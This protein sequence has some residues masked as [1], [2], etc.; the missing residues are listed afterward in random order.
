[1]ANLPPP[2]SEGVATGDQ[3]LLKRINSAALLR[4]VRTGSGLSRA[5]LAKRS[6]L[7]KSTVSLLVQEL[8]DDGWIREAEVPV[9][10]A[11]GR[12]PTPLAMDN[13]RLALLGAEIGVDYLNVVACD[14]QGRVLGEQFQPHAPGE[15][16]ATLATLVAMLGQQD[17]ALA[18]QGR[19]LLGVGVGIPGTVH[20]A[21][22]R[23]GVVPN[24]GWAGQEI[25]AP[26]A[27]LLVKGGV[28]VAPLKV[29]NEANAAALSEYVFG[30]MEGSGEG[31]HPDSLIYLSLGIGVGGGIVLGDRLHLGHDGS[32]GE[33][34]HTIL[35]L[36]GPPCRCGSRGCA[37][38]F[39]SQR[40]VSLDLTGATAPILPI[41]ELVAK[42]SAGEPAAVAATERAGRYLGMLMQNICNTLDPAVIVLGGPMG[43]LGAPYLATARAS[44][45]ALQG[46]YAFHSTEVRLCRF[47]LNA[48]A[49]GA[50]GAVL[51]DA[52]LA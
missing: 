37:E 10:G 36:D 50:A 52:L 9:S 46:R 49:V 34:G 14:L 23:I 21:G 27:A 12:R 16:P 19:R 15:L 22:R 42:V 7:T 47:G 11:V 33:V 18:R 8:I 17:A 13:S 30:D 44:F 1:M 26:L 51:H 24:L 25:A 20:G 40:A 31:V 5:D 45:Q 41:A 32:A 6:G 35:Q 38:A 48:C 28:R 39:V 43:Q 2:R 3:S 4:L 29:L